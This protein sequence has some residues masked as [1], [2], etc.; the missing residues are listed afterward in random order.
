MFFQRTWVE[1]SLN[2]IGHSILKV[3]PTHSDFLIKYKSAGFGDKRGVLIPN[4]S[5]R[6]FA[7][8]AP[9]VGYQQISSN[10]IFSNYWSDH[11]RTNMGRDFM[12]SD[13]LSWNPAETDLIKKLEEG[14]LLI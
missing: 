1:P 13:F 4:N 14:V 3:T 6:N 11:H 7:Q 12:I 9:M 10:R 2:Y 8:V 5:A